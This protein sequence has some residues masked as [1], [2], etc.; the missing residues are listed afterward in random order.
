MFNN[1]GQ[2][3][4]QDER[5]HLLLGKAVDYLY[6]IQN[7]F[8]PMVFGTLLNNAFGAQGARYLEVALRP[9]VHAQVSKNWALMNAIGGVDKL[10][11]KYTKTFSFAWYEFATNFQNVSKAIFSHRSTRLRTCL[12]ARQEHLGGPSCS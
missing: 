12:R 5:G 10:W 2:L 8:K 11:T 7:N 1:K 3:K 9:A 4:F 6:G